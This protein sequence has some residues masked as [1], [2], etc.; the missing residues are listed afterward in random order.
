MKSN[1]IKTAISIIILII[2]CYVINLIS[3][4][5]V[6]EYASI[7]A[8]QVNDNTESYKILRSRGSMNLLFNIAYIISFGLWVIYLIKLWKQK[9]VDIK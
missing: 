8:D 3:Y 1:I 5:V 2:I 4:S 9:D 7:A 6:Q